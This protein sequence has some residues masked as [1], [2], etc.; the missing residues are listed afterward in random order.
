MIE[1]YKVGI[2][3]IL[4]SNVSREMGNVARQFEQLDK[5]IKGAQRSVNELAAGMRGLSRIGQSAAEAWTVAAQAME[6]AARAAARAGASMPGPGGGGSG[7]TVSP[8]GVT[9]PTGPRAPAI[10]APFY[11]PAII[12]PAGGGYSPP[13]GGGGGGVGAFGAGGIVPYAGP[14]M[15]MGGYGRG[16]WS[17]APSGMATVLEGAGAVMAG[18]EAM[19]EDVALRGAL[20]AMG[21]A[22]GSTE[23]D[24]GIARLRKLAG[25]SAV[26]TI[27]NEQRTAS[28]MPGA[29]GVLGFGGS[30]PASREIAMK[31]FETIFPTLLRLG[32]SA[33]MLHLGSTDEAM[34]AAIGYAH[35][36]NR[37]NPAELE[38]G[39]DKLMNIAR[40]THETVAGEASVLKYSVPIAK[41]AGIEPDDAAMLTGFLQVL[42]FSGTTAGT[43][44]GQLISGLAPITITKHGANKK[45]QALQ[46]LGLMDKNG[47]ITESVAPG[48]RV[49]ADS[50][51]QH[52]ADFA[53]G[54]KP[55]DVLAVLREAFTVR[56]MR[57]AGAMEDPESISR[58]VTFVE[59]INRLP[60]ARATQEALA[61]APLQTFEQMIARFADTGNIIATQTL[62]GLKAAFEGVT[63]ALEGVNKVLRADP[64]DAALVG[65]GTIGAILGGG[66]RLAGK[67][68][69]KFGYASGGAAM[70]EAGMLLGGLG[71][72]TALAGAGKAALDYLSE[73]AY[74]MIMGKGRAEAVKKDREAAASELGHTIGEAVK[75]ALAGMG[76]MMDGKAVAK[77][78]SDR[79]ADGLSRAPA[80][81]NSPDIRINP[82]FPPL[83]LGT[84]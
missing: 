8:A 37:Y 72:L 30:D 21:F 76:I 46:A 3:L 28:T 39:L 17:V 45:A 73:T 5:I 36:T 64:E 56:G 14:G 16:G 2:S 58:M 24:K 77:I 78:V 65:Y 84:P 66:M 74:D 81:S 43:G 15:P 11:A 25:D 63:G 13:P 9:R 48:G 60:G 62:P 40:M 20:M 71:A 7:Y 35:M 26:G 1:A 6:R 67:A 79:L 27:V 52:V 32:E 70:G 38:K 44:L 57:V 41:A 34:T 31:K 61:Q 50:L 33:E 4:D 80:G 55:I 49:D 51:L 83:G 54:H 47:K 23:Y 10:A 18:R 22:P 75:S 82:S 53:K 42:G 59:Q 19:R 69:S 12:P 68:A 29:A